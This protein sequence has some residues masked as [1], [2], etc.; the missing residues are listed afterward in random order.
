MRPFS[1]TNRAP[2]DTLKQKREKGGIP[3]RPDDE[4]EFSMNG[5]YTPPTQSYGT[6]SCPQCRNRIPAGSPVCPCCGCPVAAV[7]ERKYKN[8]R[9]TIIAVASVAVAAV[10]V[11]FLCYGAVIA[12]VF[13]TARN[14]GDGGYGNGYH[15]Y[16]GGWDDGD[17]YG[18]E[19]DGGSYF[20]QQAPSGW[21][22][23]DH[24]NRR[25]P[26]ATHYAV[27]QTASWEE[28]EFTVTGVR[29]GSEY[30]LA[31]DE[32]DE[33]LVVQIKITNHSGEDRL[34]W[35]PDFILQGGD[36]LFEFS[37]DDDAYITDSQ[38]NRQE[39]FTTQTLAAGRTI[40]TTLCYEVPKGSQDLELTYDNDDYLYNPQ[41]RFDLGR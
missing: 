2:A 31:P 5:Y 13:R 19:G 16:Q 10:L 41:L 33:Y 34:L 23:G 24:Q 11:V 38:G 20:D 32:D 8:L 12:A 4:E 30:G 29:D 18:D 36:D 17:D 6:T 26:D 35:R 39:L 1:L 21:N 3:A 37:E 9:N 25:T 7:R 22:S 40:E 27:G 28:M 14:Y 15:H